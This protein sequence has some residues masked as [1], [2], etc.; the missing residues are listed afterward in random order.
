MPNIVLEDGTGVTGS[1]V[2]A[3]QEYVTTFAEN[4]GMHEWEDNFDLQEIAMINAAQFIDLRYSEM[5]CGI[6]LTDTQGLLFPRHT[7]LGSTGIPES[8]KKA[9]AYASIMYIRN[10][11]LALDANADGGRVVSSESVSVA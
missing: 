5:Y 2:Y 8:L 4:M 10:G 1:T 11:S 6:P 9:F 3:S 7:G